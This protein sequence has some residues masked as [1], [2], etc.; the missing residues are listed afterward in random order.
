MATVEDL[1]KNKPVN[2][3]D[4][5]SVL[6]G[7]I[8]DLKNA[9]KTTWDIEHHQTGEHKIKKGTTVAR[10][11]AGK[12]GRVYYNDDENDIQRDDGASW[13]NLGYFNNVKIGTYSG[14]GAS[15]SITGVGFLPLAVLVV[16]VDDGIA[17]L[18][19]SGFAA[20]DTAVLST[21]TIS[22]DGIDTLDADGF[23]VSDG[24]SVSGKTYA[25]IALKS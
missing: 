14:S 20:L 2:A 15:K 12:A 16:R 17:Y 7:E 23:S 11:A 18:K 4:A 5:G 8:R 19:T 21:G 9:V 24:I 3:T 13:I 6:G 22:T 10:P 25:Y 1:D